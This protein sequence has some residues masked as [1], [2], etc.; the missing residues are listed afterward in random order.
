[1]PKIIIHA[2][3]GAF[4]AAARQGIAKNLTNFALDCER[5]P[6][7]PFVKS[8]VWI[9]FN[10]HARD[11]VFMGEQPASLSVVS[12]Q[13]FV[14]AG[15]L[16]ADAKKKLIKGTTE[17]FGQHLCVTEPVPVYIVV[18]EIAEANW[19]IFGE[20]PDLAALRSSPADAAA[21]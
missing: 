12:V 6:K 11:A 15:G 10:E 17:I 4:D 21:I 5:L 9:Y 3:V 1:M 7:S 19:G 2:P 18:H 8:T 20:N 13:I 16:D 14:I